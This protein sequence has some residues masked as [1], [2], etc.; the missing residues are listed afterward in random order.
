M[1]KAFSLDNRTGSYQVF[2]GKFYCCTFFM[3]S[4]HYKRL[5]TYTS[6]FSTYFLDQGIASWPCIC[7]R[8]TSSKQKFK[9]LYLYIFIAFVHFFNFLPNG[10]TDQKH[11]NLFRTD[12]YR[13]VFPLL[14]ADSWSFFSVTAHGSY[15]FF[16]D[17]SSVRPLV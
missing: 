10:K 14:G 12:C 1:I 6:D 8:A 9:K 16:R 13:A 7:S 4:Q 17:Y 5:R 15:T 2:L 11:C 3:D